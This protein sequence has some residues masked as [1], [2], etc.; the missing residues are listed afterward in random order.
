MP[1]ATSNLQ[2]IKEKIRRLTR[3]PS[4]S[5]LSDSEL[6]QYINTF[7]LY[8]FPQNIKI[9]DLKKTLTFYTKPNID[10]YDTET[11]PSTDPLYDFKNKYLSIN[12]PVY[13]AGF[14]IFYGQ[15][16]EQFFG[17]YP[18]LSSI[19]SIGS[20]GDGVTVSFSGTIS[21]IPFLQN[22]VLFSSVDINNDALALIDTPIS[23]T[24]GNLSIPNQAPTSTIVQDPNNFVNYITGAFVIT[25]ATAP[26]SGQAIN[27]QVFSYVVARPQ[28]MLFYDSTF[29]VRPVPD[30]PYPVQMEVYVRPTELLDDA[31]NPDLN[32]YWQYIVYG[33]SIKILQDRMDMESVQMLQP[34]FRKQE[35]LVLRKT[36]ME[37]ANQ[38]T[39]TIYTEN[40]AGQYGPGFFNGGGSF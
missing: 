16:R 24:I 25:F 6:E 22:D 32:Q 4:D 28:A 31:Q 10:S 9:F 7:I 27:S 30:Q 5:Q 38:R 2:T 23:A 36:I 21:N 14:E 20:A 19:A 40:V 17:I 35:V 39:A 18:K 13:C 11:A 15:S 29:T 33:S 12:P 34:E 26:A 8:D 3:S 37:N 1:A